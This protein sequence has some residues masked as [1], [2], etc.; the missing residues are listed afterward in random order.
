MTR[1]F[2]A[3]IILIGLLFTSAP[4][5]HKSL[6]QSPKSTVYVTTYALESFTEALAGD[7]VEVKNFVPPAADLHSWEP[8]ARDMAALSEADLL[9]A[10]G[11]GLEPWLDKVVVVMDE[12]KVID[13][14]ESVDLLPSISHMDHAN[15]DLEHDHDEVDTHE[16]HDHA[17][18]EEHDADDSHDHDADDH[19]DHDHGAFDPHFWVDPYAAE[20][21]AVAVYEALLQLLPGEEETLDENFQDLKEQFEALKEQADELDDGPGRAFVV[22]HGGFRYLAIR[23]DLEQLALNVADHSEPSPR[24]LAVIIERAKELELTTVLYDSRESSKQA[25]VVA[26]A[27]EGEIVPIQ[28][29][30]YVS[31]E[32]RAD[33]RDY[34]ARMSEMLETLQA[35]LG[36]SG[37]Q[38]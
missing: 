11:A 12:S 13:S 34:F 3:F 7:L 16:E 30:E 26:A 38:D 37:E 17:E 23:Y 4:L 20:Q 33:G 25:E 10:N 15:E 18:D 28:T 24:D 21:Q 8:T 29:F 31:E 2:L 6:A 1:R 19:H 27:I 35:A 14:S 9:I 5:T 22:T 32:E 36:G